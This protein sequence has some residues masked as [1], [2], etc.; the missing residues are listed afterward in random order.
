MDVQL[1]EL[2]DK[3]KK[4]GIASAEETSA[5][6]IEEAEKNAQSIISEAK[7]KA[8]SIIKDAKSETARMEKAGVDAIKQAARN[9]LISFRDGITSELN[10]IV[11]TKTTESYSKDLMARLIPETVKAWAVKSDSSELSVLLSEK[12]LAALQDG[13]MSELKAEISKGLEVK[14]DKTLS[15]GF[16]IGLKD[17]SAFYDYSSESVAQLFASY[18]NPK[19]AAIMKEAANEGLK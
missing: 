9:I 12:D 18:L 13:L 3:I 4:D 2:I 5:K 19:T 17:G 6:I 8:D 16:R 11:E 1:Q 15:G 7:N 10:S 14:S